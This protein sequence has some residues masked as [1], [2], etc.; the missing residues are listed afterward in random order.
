MQQAKATGKI[1]DP[2]LRQEIAKLLILSKCGVPL[3]A[4]SVAF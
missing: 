1:N 2:V 3:G 4:H